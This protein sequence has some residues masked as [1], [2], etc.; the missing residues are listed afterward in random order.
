MVEPLSIATGVI[1]LLSNS[2]KFSKDI[3][4]LIDSVQSAPKHIRDVSDDLKA[5][6]TTLGILDCLLRDEQIARNALIRDLSVNLE[7]ALK[8]CVRVLREIGLVVNA[9]VGADGTAKT[10][11]W[12]RTKWPF[13]GKEARGL[14]DHLATYKATCMMTIN[15]AT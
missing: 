9:F 8:N 1:S 11:S 5:L 2:Y 4:E 12:S 14:R 15:T 3:Y 13:K 6:Y 10:S 7:E